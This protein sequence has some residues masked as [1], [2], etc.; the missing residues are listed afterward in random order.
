MTVSRWVRRDRRGRFD[1]EAGAAN[2]PT[3]ARAMV[4]CRYKALGCSSLLAH[5]D[6]GGK[7]IFIPP[8]MFVVYGESLLN[9]RGAG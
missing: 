1:L 3:G 7:M 9:Y 2:L 4:P 5:L 6:E 8:L